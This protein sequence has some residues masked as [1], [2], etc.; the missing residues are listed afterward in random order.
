MLCVKDFSGK[1]LYEGEMFPG[2][3]GQYVEKPDEI[4]YCCIGG[5]TNYLYY[6][7]VPA[8]GGTCA[9]RLDIQNGMKADVLWNEKNDFKNVE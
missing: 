9:I 8:D 4:G 5:D 6:N 7:I 1:T 3:L 2:G